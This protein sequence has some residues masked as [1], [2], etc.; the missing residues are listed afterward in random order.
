M[1]QSFGPTVP[2]TLSA[3]P[4]PGNLHLKD[5]GLGGLF[6]GLLIGELLVATLLPRH[7][8]DDKAHH[9]QEPEVRAISLQAC[10]FAEFL[11]FVG[12]ETGF[13]TLVPFIMR[14][15]DDAG[16]IFSATRPDTLARKP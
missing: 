15:L 12:E 1:L 6:L 11:R 16:L 5:Y 9:G 2:A 4:S 8:F 14:V 13:Q 10:H 3:A 7:R